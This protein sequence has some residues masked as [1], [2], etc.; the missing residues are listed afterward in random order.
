MK[1]VFIL[2]IIL[3]FMYQTSLLAGNSESS[4]SNDSNSIP[5]TLIKDDYFLSGET[6]LIRV[7]IW[8]EVSKPG[9]YMVPDKTNVVELISLAGGPTELA[10]ISNIRITHKNPKTP[11]ERIIKVNV[12]NYLKK[13]KI[14]H[15][16]P[17]KPGDVIYV[18]H[19]TK[20][21]WREVVRIIADIAII[22]N[23]V[24]L[25]YRNK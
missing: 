1:K 14:E 19:N 21:T 15:L 10:N 12:N 8:G 13:N 18:P 16:S 7:H 9:S 17:L 25:I 24:Y 5:S 4:E 11:E 22:A 20:Y 3:L 23:V 2:T 6:L